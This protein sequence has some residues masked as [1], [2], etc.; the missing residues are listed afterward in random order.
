MSTGS[1]NNHSIS[2][3]RSAFTLVELLVVIAIIAMLV[4]LLLPAVQSAREA[5]RRI[6]CVNN[7]KQLALA[8]LNYESANGKFPPPGYA[9][10][11][12]NPTILFG[13]FVPN[14]GKQ[15]SWIVLT[16]PFM[17]E[18]NLFDQ[19]DLTKTVFNQPRAATKAQPPSL[20]CASDNAEGRELRSGFSNGRA[21][22]KTNYAAWATPYHLDLQGLFAGAM[23]SWGL[24]L[25]EVEDGLSKTYMLSEVLTRADIRDQRGAWALPWNAASLLAYDAHHNFKNDGLQYYPMTRVTDFMQ[26]PN[27]LGP[28]V[29]MIYDCPRPESAQLEGQPCGTFEMGTNSG[30]HSAAP[31][32]YHAGGVNVALM[33]GSVTFVPN[34]VDPIAMAFLVSVDD[35]QAQSIQQ[36]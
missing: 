7:Q 36:Q 21:F 32:S 12:K 1:G 26:R 17:E 19:F 33:D 14:E 29:D 13:E 2:S 35:G 28:N 30:Y 4:S 18:Q 6:S 23:G 11:N 24:K 8:L 25:K 10:I 31:R 5:G 3:T 15:F 20:M 16:L 22:G 9:G 34:D 27:H